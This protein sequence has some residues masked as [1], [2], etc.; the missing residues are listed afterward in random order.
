MGQRPIYFHR[1][2]KEACDSWKNR[3]S[4]AGGTVLAC[5]GRLV[6]QLFLATNLPDNSL[7]SQGLFPSGLFGAYCAV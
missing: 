5:S 6:I 2:S 3:V 7:G 1:E 4:K